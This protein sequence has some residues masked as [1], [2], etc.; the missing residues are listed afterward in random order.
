MNTL[1]ER[2][3]FNR[4]NGL[5]ITSENQW[6][7]LFSGRIEEFF[8]NDYKPDAFFCISDK[9]LIL[10]YN[11]PADKPG[12]FK[13]VWNFNESPIVIIQ[14]AGAIEIYNGFHFL[15]EY[16]ELSK[17]NIND[18]EDF[19]YFGLLS[20]EVWDKYKKRFNYKYRV[21]YR[22]LDNIKF[23]RKLLLDN[24]H[25]SQS[26]VNRLIG[27]CI[28]TRYLIDRRV[29]I[30]FQG[31]TE[32]IEY[33]DNDHFA[34]VL[35][36][37]AEVIE[38]FDF[39]QEKFNGN[40]FSI[41]RAEYDA[42]DQ[43]AL[44]I[45][46]ELIKGSEIGEGVSQPSLF[47]LYDF[48]IIPVEFISNVYEMFIGEDVQ[49][50]KG[51]YYTP[52]FLVDYILSQTMDKYFKENPEEYNCKIL[53]PAC[54]SG[55]FLVEAYRKIVKQFE[56]LHPEIKENSEEYQGALISLVE[57]N[58][59]GI[60]KDDDAVS[61]ATFSLY[62]TMLHFQSPPDIENFRFPILAENNFFNRDFFD[63]ELVR[64]ERLIGFDF[65]IG[66]PPW[67]RGNGG[68]ATSPYIQY[69]NVRREK[70]GS[71]IEIGNNE[72]AQSF[73]LRTSDFSAAKTE[74]ALI[75]TSK[76]L[77]NLQSKGFRRYFL[78]N[79]K[80]KRVFELAAVRREVFNKSG[81]I[82]PAAIIFFSF[83]QG[84]NTDNEIIE[85]ISLKPS[86]FFSLFR[87][88]TLQ[89]NDYKKV[90]QKKLKEYDYLWKILV[91]GSYLDFNFIR[92]LKGNYGTVEDS[93]KE[94][95]V[96]KGEGVVVGTSERYSA[97]EYYNKLFLNPRRTIV[98][99][100][101]IGLDYN[102]RF[103][104]RFLDW[105]R[106][107]DLFLSPVLLISKGVSRG[108]NPKTAIL[109][110]DAIYT[111]AF[112]GVRAND[113][114][115]LR[116]LNAL[117]TS[118]ISSYFIFQIAS[119]VGIEREQIHDKENWSLPYRDNEQIPEIV[120]NI[121]YLKR[122]F[123]DNSTFLFSEEQFKLEQ[124]ID[125]AEK[126]LDE[127]VL[128]NFD[129]TE[130]ERALVDYTQEIMIPL[131]MRHRGYEERVWAS[132]RE[133]SELEEYVAVFVKRFSD[134]F[135]RMGFE[136][137]IDIWR[138][139]SLIGIFFHEVAIDE[140]AAVLRQVL[141]KTNE[142]FLIKIAALGV[143]KIS[144]RLFIQRDIR[145]F[146]RDGFYIIKPNEKRLW[147]KAIAYLDAHEIADAMLQAGREEYRV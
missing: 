25:I 127:K 102:C 76:V 101:Y 44:N 104:F 20:G 49:A 42:V 114:R 5:Y 53:D 94:K 47:D 117:I 11:E 77:Y 4:E 50:N 1:F 128:E 138:N 46:A 29:R 132:I 75:V 55:I 80:I 38:L 66:N 126:I 3:G 145:G 7:G 14:D 122:R 68:N 109:Y 118:K 63:E 111:D 10:F 121:E 124:Q 33:L 90:V 6:S 96:I 60:D 140:G 81:Q 64:N 21:D 91:Y 8:E 72:I 67:K 45:L 130:E 27:K 30:S 41:E 2:L 40:L 52:V 36:I 59:F 23:A 87:I 113:I 97:E 78:D 98:K 26:L 93:F 85:H 141:D 86:R 69:V 15:V 32:A 84:N 146:E 133:D 31:V 115:Y 131:I 22:L 79:Y 139:T 119:S 107:N 134:T 74:C 92:R 57:D 13:G 143:D 65:I 144:E 123:F 58:I 136:L 89:R 106:T 83:T 35:E 28:F 82:A 12:I 99:N 129:L 116:T 71:L 103:T 51:A 142:D 112:T 110:E 95:D 61:V 73:L 105:K 56:R 39:L 34:E 43:G 16:S 54:G 19:S 137:Q 120:E 125:E 100:F 62:L 70:E 17:I 48:S 37:K 9:P 108:I 88:F 147:H 18:L 135:R 24:Y